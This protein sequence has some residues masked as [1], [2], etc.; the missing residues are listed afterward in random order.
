MNGSSAAVLGLFVFAEYCIET[1]F[2]RPLF[3][4]AVVLMY[5]GSMV[6]YCENDPVV[7]DLMLVCDKFLIDR[8]HPLLLACGAH[9]AVSDAVCTIRVC[10][11]IRN[12]NSLYKAVSG[13][14]F[15]VLTLIA[16]VSN[17]REDMTLIV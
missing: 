10:N 4:F 5:I 2:N 16:V 15:N 7:V 12:K 17:F 9:T 14:Y 1:I 3:L 6:C 13:L 11:P 8:H